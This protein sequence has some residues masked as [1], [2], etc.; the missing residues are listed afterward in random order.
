MKEEKMTTFSI[1][2]D[3]GNS[4][5]LSLYVIPDLTMAWI[6]DAHRT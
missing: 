5:T 2:R 4:F 1:I 6:L 3:N